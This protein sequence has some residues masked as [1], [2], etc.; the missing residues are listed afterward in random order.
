MTVFGWLGRGVL[1]LLGLLMAAN[2]VGVLY[3]SGTQRLSISPTETITLMWDVWVVSWIVAVVWSRPT[4][5]RPA[6]LD[7]LVHWLPTLVGLLLLAFGSLWT[8]FTPLWNL[9]DIANWTLTGACAAG[10][11]FTW[12][13]RISLGSLWSGS[14]GRKEGHTV[15]QSGPYRFVRHPIYT[16]LILAAFAQAIQVGQAANLLGAVLMTFGLWLKARLEERFL[17]LELGPEAYA[18]YRRRT[19]M[20]VPFWPVRG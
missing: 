12:W 19:P 15:I 7:Q 2:I 17:S 10:L 4:A 6:T 14:V 9:P 16:G 1:A 13:A 5:A 3:L 8:N 18:D 20:L 11:L